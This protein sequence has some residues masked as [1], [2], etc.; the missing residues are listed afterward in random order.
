MSKSLLVI[1]ALLLTL[2]P[3]NAATPAP[4]AIARSP[5]EDALLDTDARQRKAVAT[6]D[7]ESLAALSH[8]NLRI[9]APS[10]R[11]L[12]GDDL[13]RMVKSG[14]IRNEVFERTPETVVITGDVGVVMGREVVFPA[15]KASRR[16]CMA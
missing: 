6:V 4:A 1:T 14:D 2:T 16:G 7:L 13:L 5:D 11:V 10:N 15:R 9:N 8:R 3:A 12:T